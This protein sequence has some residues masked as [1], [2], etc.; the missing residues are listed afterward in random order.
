[1]IVVMRTVGTRHTAEDTE[2]LAVWVRGLTG[3]PAVTQTAFAS[4]THPSHGDEPAT[5]FYAEGDA[6]AGV[7]RLRCLAG[8]HAHDILDSAEHWT[9]PHVWA[10]IS[11]S[12]S[13]A[14]VVYGIHDEAGTAKW[15][16]VAVRCVECG[17][18]AGLTDMVLGDMPLDDLL[19]IL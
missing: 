7:A 6:E 17:D 12:Q 1:L 14:E 8:G 15:L 4:C 16:V 9:F 18:V 11:C 13:I 5:W 3:C 10:C 2:D 19:A